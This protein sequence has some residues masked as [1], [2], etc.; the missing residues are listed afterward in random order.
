MR[1]RK[2]GSGYKICENHCRTGQK[3]FPLASVTYQQIL[4][5]NTILI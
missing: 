1:L 2:S 5:Y 3:Y 4:M